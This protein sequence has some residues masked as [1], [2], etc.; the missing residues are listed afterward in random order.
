MDFYANIDECP[1]DYY[2]LWTDFDAK[3]FK[4]VETDEIGLEF[5]LNHIKI[6]SIHKLLLDDY[7]IFLYDLK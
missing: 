6:L 3:N 2:N 1:N 7:I 4:N 5:I